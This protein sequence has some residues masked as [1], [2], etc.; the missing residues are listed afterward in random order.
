MAAE[1]PGALNAEVARHRRLCDAFEAL[2]PLDAEAR[3]SALAAQD[4]DL[5]E[6]LRA[7]LQASAGQGLAPPSAQP[8]LVDAAGIGSERGYRVLREIGRG[9]MGRVLLAERADGRFGRQV[10]I[11]VLDRSAA[12]ADWRRRFAAERE[13]LARLRHPNIA[14]LLDAGEAADGTP[15]LVMEWIDGVPLDAW[16]RTTQPS[17]A[18][19]IALFEAIARAVAHAHQALVAHRDLK[20]ANVLVDAQ[21]AP[22]LLDF[23]IAR[24]LGD[25]AAAT[26]TGLH[27]LTPRYAAPEQVEGGPASAAVDI[28]QLGLLLF[29]L[30][31][32]SPPFAELQGAALLN[33]ILQRELPAPSTL[34]RQ[35]LAK[36]LRGDLDAIVA[37]ALRRDP[38]QRY[39]SAEALLDDLQRWREGRPVLAR[40]GGQLYRLRK[41][42]RRQRLLLGAAALVVLLTA[43]FILRLQQELARS[44]REQATAKQVTELMIA[45]LSEADPRQAQGRELTL[46]E[47]LEQ[48]IERVRAEQGMPDA[49]RGRLLHALGVVFS[50]LSDFVRAEALLLEA[51]PLRERAGEGLDGANTAYSIAVLRQRQG[52]IDEAKQML[53]HTI[54]LLKASA[55]DD[56]RFLA[57][58]HN[59]SAILARMSGDDAAAAVHFEQALALLRAEGGDALEDLGPTLRN[60]AEFLDDRGE[61]ARALAQLVEAQANVDAWTPG[62]DPEQSRLLRVLGRNALFR[63]DAA[64]AQRYLAES[65]AM[66]QRLF[67]GDHD[68]KVRVADLA[69]QERWAAGEIES[70]HAL[71][72]TAV[73]QGL[74]LYPDGHL[75]LYGAELRLAALALL[76]GERESAR[77]L[78]RD[79]QR[80]RSDNPVA[81]ADRASEA[82]LTAVVE[83][84]EPV[85]TALAAL[86]ADQR[87]LP[88]L[89]PGWSAVAALCPAP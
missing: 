69:A 29:Q 56:R 86:L 49:V 19:R 78:L 1:D 46:R 54:T 7:M 43:G 12:D 84:R 67:P 13:I 66:A 75:R 11:K 53:A 61:H 31:S 42:L 23:G 20:P 17:L 79:A 21:D 4:A 32:E 36:A 82:L 14:R 77:S 22:H 70:A 40:R 58:M 55:P 83:C 35:P 87:G 24:L 85:D 37:Q 10:A 38:A 72:R 25:E 6:E 76:R 30:L 89:R 80:S 52:R 62:D 47:A 48:G 71:L 34:A 63:G 39:R 74:R 2:Q 18:Q 81:S 59:G 3:E 26:E 88:W 57:E 28:Y 44:E 33:A 5:V 41:F 65:W 64:A 45:V 50:Q 9:G 15:Y 60:H 27:A 16:L 73:D 68:E 8:A 51:L